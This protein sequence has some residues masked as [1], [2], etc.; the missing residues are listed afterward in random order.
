MHR[1]KTHSWATSSNDRTLPAVAVTFF[2]FFAAAAGAGVV[3]AD[4]GGSA[5]RFWRF[6]LGGAGLILEVLL[7]A[8]LFAIELARYVG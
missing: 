4:L 1:F 2:V 7:L 8:L 5:D 3:A 6:G